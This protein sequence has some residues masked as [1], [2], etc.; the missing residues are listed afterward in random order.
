MGDVRTTTTTT[1]V[2]GKSTVL[3]YVLWFFLGTFGVHRLYLGRVGTGVLQLLLGIIGVIT[4]FFLVGWFLLVVLWIWLLVDLFLI[5]GMVR[6]SRNSNALY[7]TV[8]STTVVEE[9]TNSPSSES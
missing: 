2:L 3:A 5:P 1:V 6:S 9:T 8:T 7:H 4:T